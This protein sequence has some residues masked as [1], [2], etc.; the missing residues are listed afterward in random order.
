MEEL[1]HLQQIALYGFLLAIVFGAIAAKTN[2]CTMGAV[3]DIVNI[4]LPWSYECLVVRYW[5]RHD[6]HHVP[7]H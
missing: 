6:W 7:A 3:S 4:G 1:T 5:C 2:F